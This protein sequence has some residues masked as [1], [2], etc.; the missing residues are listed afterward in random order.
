MLLL[1]IAWSLLL[2]VTFQIGSTFLDLNKGVYF[3]RI[4]DRFVISVW[5]GIIILSNM[6][7]AISVISRLSLLVVSILSF[8]LMLFSILISRKIY[9]RTLKPYLSLELILGFIFLLIGISFVTTQVVVWYDTGGY[10][11]GIIK[12][13]SRYG[14]VP[15]LALIYYGFGYTSSWFA[16]GASFN[17]WILDARTS[18]LTGGFAFLIAILHFWICLVRVFINR[19]KIE[20]WFIVISSLLAF[21]VITRYEIYVS[22]SQDLPIIILTIV[23]AWTIIII[24]RNESRVLSKE[25]FTNSDKGI[26]PLILSAGAVSMKL[27]AI[28]IL[29][30]SVF[31]YVFLKKSVRGILNC[32][33]ITFLLLL[34]FLAV[35]AITSGCLSYPS[36][37]VCVDLPWSIGTE[38]IKAVSEQIRKAAQWSSIT[39]PDTNSWRWLLQWYIREKYQNGLIL[40]AIISFYSSI[41]ELCNHHLHWAKWP[42][43]MGIIGFFYTILLG[44]TWR[45]SL[46]YLSIT[47]GIFMSIYFGKKKSA[48]NKVLSYFQSVVSPKLAP[49]VFLFLF[50][51]TIPLL[52]IMVNNLKTFNYLRLEIHDAARK[53][54][55]S[56][57]IY[58]HYRLILPPPI[59]NFQLGVKYSGDKMLFTVSDLELV[60][61]KV[62][63]F[64]FYKPKNG[65]QCWNAELP[66][67]QFL[68]YDNIKLRYPE[69]GIGKGFV[70]IR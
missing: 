57:D 6:L 37:L 68:T 64:H 63:D 45:Y 48:F 59:L 2:M 15:G 52:S 9:V 55:L 61:E 16:L 65:Y 35:Q 3:R 10:H 25:L 30:V 24:S 70:R 62:N 34:P 11:F 40:L 28:P 50:S 33:L 13:L 58:K 32:A 1:I 41:K 39:P 51:I 17:D 36:S 4:G 38:K 27:S 49:V 54:E 21:A 8:G 23:T 22:P 67:T 66:C 18:T 20:D 19:A 69:V 42:I 12:W 56:L 26:I 29:L 43:A 7:L 5:L 44:P 31:F 14:A 60:E 46:G 53:G 47:S